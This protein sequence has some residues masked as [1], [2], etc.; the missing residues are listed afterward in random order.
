MFFPQTSMPHTRML[1]TIM[2]LSKKG[3]MAV[4]NENDYHYEQKLRSIKKRRKI[5][6]DFWEW[7]KALIIAVVIALVI[8]VFLFAPIVVE[9]KSMMSTLHNSERLIVNKAVYHISEPKRGEILVFHAP[10]AN[11]WIKRV[12]GVSGDIVEVSDG[13][14]YVNGEEL[15]E[16]YLDNSVLSSTY[17][18]REVVPS[19]RIFVMGDNRDHSRDSRDIGSIS[20]DEVVGRAE[21]V[22]WP[23]N[24]IRIVERSR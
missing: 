21:V 19:G 16:S 23:F 3:T 10:N 8:R 11:D 7:S 20:I 12:I 24:E 18:F 6:S 9:G 5:K 17:D 1:Q 2:L 15:D 4:E 22:F 14:L 13:V